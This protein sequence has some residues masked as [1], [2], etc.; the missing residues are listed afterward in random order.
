MHGTAITTHYWDCCKPSCSWPGKA[1]VSAPVAACSADDSP[2]A[3]LMERNGCDENGSAF[4]CSNQQ[5]WAVNDTLAY[6]FA[7]AH[8]SHTTEVSTCCAC[9]QLAFHSG[10]LQGKSMVVQ[11][12]NTGADLGSNH[13]DIAVPGGG[14][15]LFSGCFA[16]FP[17]VPF[18]AWGAQEGGNMNSSGCARLP[19]SLQP[20]CHFRYDW[21]SGLRQHDAAFQR[22]KCP[23]EIVARSG[24]RRGDDGSW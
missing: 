9:Y 24:C 17:D 13:F 19:A 7:A 8:M 11:V 18:S 14:Q 22:V 10:A 4:T 2:L 23:E 3:D 20:G 16:Q 5:P 21:A 6:G 12:T 15:G 1:A